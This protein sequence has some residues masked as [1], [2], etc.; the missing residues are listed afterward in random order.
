MSKKI[1]TSSLRN[2]LFKDISVFLDSEGFVHSDIHTEGIMLLINLVS[3]YYEEGKHLYPEVII[4]HDLDKLQ[5][6]VS[7]RVFIKECKFDVESF[8]EALKLC[9][10][11]AIDGW[12][13]YIELKQ[14]NIR[15]G[16]FSTEITETSLS[17]NRQTMYEDSFSDEATFAYIRCVGQK[18]VELRGKHG[19]V[20]VCLNLDEE[21]DLSNNEIESLSKIISSRCDDESKDK[22]S[23]YFEKVIDNSLKAGHGNLIGV[24][25]DCPEKITN[26]K[27]VLSDG[28]YLEEPIDMAALVSQ[29]EY[30]KSSSNSFSLRAYASIMSAMINHDGITLMTDTGKLLGYHLFVRSG[31]KDNEPVGGARSRA[32]ESMKSLELKACFYK[33]QDGNMKLY[34]Y[35]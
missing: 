25:E 31:S 15:F 34:E 24:V 23:V 2:S 7:R 14:E 19:S 9:A 28:I 3:D 21:K 13:I 26:I 33:S 6:T 8:R 29:A 11:L 35:K 1:Q 30:D 17:L 32:F 20:Q 5:L 12:V 18:V 10:P 27:S 4:T 22:L 16:V